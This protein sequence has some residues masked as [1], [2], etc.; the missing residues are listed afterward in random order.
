MVKVME[1]G[2]KYFCPI[3]SNEVVVTNAGGGKLVCCGQPMEL[4]EPVE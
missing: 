2:E 3:C 4:V 1:V